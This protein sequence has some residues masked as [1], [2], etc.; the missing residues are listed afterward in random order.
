VNI[1]KHKFGN[2][3]NVIINNCGLSNVCR[4][5]VLYSNEEGSALSSLT[6]RNL[7]H[8]NIE[9]SFTE[10]VTLKRFDDYWDDNTI[11][12]VIDLFKI[13]VEGHEM[14]V[15][16][17]IGNKIDRIKVIQRELGGA[18][19]D[20]RMFFRDFY[21]FFENNNFDIYRIT[22]FG[23]LKINKYKEKYERFQT[24]NYFSINRNLFQK[25]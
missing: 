4:K 3:G 15:L 8:F 24:T 23:S 17:G 1:L 12:D 20:T 14:A 13:D 6:K 19:I 5:D 7:D 9:F 10:E 18:N 2:R 25:K 21:H 16:E 22:P 11:G